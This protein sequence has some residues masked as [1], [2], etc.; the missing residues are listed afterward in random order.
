MKKLE[1]RYQMELTHQLLQPP[2][3][4][5]INHILNLPRPIKLEMQALSC[6]FLQRQLLADSL[7]CIIPLKKNVI[8]NMAIPNSP[9]SLWWSYPLH[10]ISREYG[11]YL[12][13]YYIVSRYQHSI[14]LANTYK[15]VRD[16]LIRSDIFIYIYIGGNH[17][18]M[19][20]PSL[21]RKKKVV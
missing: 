18:L 19:C 21:H 2:L 5:N 17:E 1:L 10:F 15:T 11:K 4:S 16:I 12:T 14:T 7:N 3:H 13:V 9:N 8:R 6:E 20:P